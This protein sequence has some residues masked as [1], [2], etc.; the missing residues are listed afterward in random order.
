MFASNSRQSWDWDE[1]ATSPPNNN[2]HIESYPKKMCDTIYS[3]TINGPLM[4][5]GWKRK[6]YP[7]VN[8]QKTMENHHAIHGKIHYTWWF[9]IVMLNYQRVNLHFPMVFLWF[10][11]GFPMLSGFHDLRTSTWY[12]GINLSW[13]CL[14]GTRR[15]RT[16]NSWGPLTKLRS[17]GLWYHSL[18]F[19]Y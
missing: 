2:C 9:S 6:I 19:N 11:Y 10:S 8:I 1:E 4:R 18:W 3:H 16:Y 7:L 15:K 17:V 13:R 12:S 14:V 5:L